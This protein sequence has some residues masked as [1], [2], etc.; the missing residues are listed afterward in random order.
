MAQV[1]LYFPD[2]TAAR[3]RQGARRARK[4]LS[5]YVLTLIDHPHSSADWKARVRALSGS[6]S[7]PAPKR[8]RQQKP[9]VV[10]F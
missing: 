1:S 2:E 3:L 6:W 8:P 9:R 10:S 5:A 4:S 7:G